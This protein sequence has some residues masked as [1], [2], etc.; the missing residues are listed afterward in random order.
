[1]GTLRRVATSLLQ[2]REALLASN[3]ASGLAAAPASRLVAA[4][5]HS[6]SAL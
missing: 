3:P 1:V 4:Q 6:T 2:H 5:R